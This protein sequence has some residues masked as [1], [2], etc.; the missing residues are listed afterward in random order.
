MHSWIRRIG[1]VRGGGSFFTQRWKFDICFQSV[2]RLP[3]VGRPADV[4]DRLSTLL[5]STLGVGHSTLI[6]IRISYLVIRIS[7]KV[8]NLHMRLDQIGARFRHNFSGFLTDYRLPM[9]QIGP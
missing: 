5:H 7:F 6:K 9:V 1:S 2:F 3:E 4:E 8:R